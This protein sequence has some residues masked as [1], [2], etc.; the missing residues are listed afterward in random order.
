MH[1]ILLKYIHNIIR[2]M[3]FY[4]KPAQPARSSLHINILVGCIVPCNTL[5][6][7][8][9]VHPKLLEITHNYEEL[10]LLILK[11]EIEKAVKSLKKGK[12]P[13]NDN[14]PSELVQA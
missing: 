4:K 6:I 1:F 13:G 7:C 2:Y 5:S 11:S 14:I 3:C 12:S 9:S 8:P 10:S